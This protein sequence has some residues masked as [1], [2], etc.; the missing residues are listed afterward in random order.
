MKN[1]RNIRQFLIY[2]LAFVFVIGISFLYKYVLSARADG[3]VIKNTETE[4]LVSYYSSEETS[5]IILNTTNSSV[6]S[7]ESVSM[8]SIYLCG[9]VVNP[10]VY[11]VASGTLLYEVV[12]L[13]GGFTSDAASEYI[14]LVFELESN[15]S[16]YIPTMQE[17]RSYSGDRSGLVRGDDDYFI[18]GF[19]VVDASDETSIS[20]DCTE[21]SGLININTASLEELIT[22]P[23]IGESTAQAIIDYRQTNSFTTIEDIMNVSGIGEA[24]FNRIRNYICV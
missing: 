2:A 6:I 11:S 21:S 8:I 24:K 14:N 22:L 4:E 9:A 13:A 18:W 17:L 5:E 15:L 1:G 12:D 3:M 7:S 19:D 20:S 16:I 23:G 10:G